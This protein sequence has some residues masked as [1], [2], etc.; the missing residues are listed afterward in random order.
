MQN[1]I[2]DRDF[3]YTP[4]ESATCLHDPHTEAEV[5]VALRKLKTGKSPGSDWTAAEFFKQ[6]STLIVPVLTL[7]FNKIFDSGHIPK[8]WS[9]SII[10]LIYK[11]GPR[12]DPDN[13]RR[14]SLINVIS[15]LCTLVLTARLNNWC[16]EQSIIDEAHAGFRRSYSTIDNIFTLQSIAQKYISKP[17]GR[18]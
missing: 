15:K 4:A 13:F 10:C 8:S 18:F 16:E 14:I 11:K 6:T 17:G 12:D 9:K 3:N 7:L 5:R 2:G 1:E